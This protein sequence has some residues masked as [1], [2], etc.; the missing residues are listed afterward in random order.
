MNLKIDISAFSDRKKAFSIL[1][2]FLNN[3]GYQITR[4]KDYSVQ[5]TS[6]CKG[7]KRFF[8]ELVGKVKNV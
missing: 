5:Y 2:K 8:W 6:G 7:L 4:P 1:N 3:E